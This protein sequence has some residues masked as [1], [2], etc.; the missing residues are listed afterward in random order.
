MPMSEDQ[1]GRR[2]GTLT[3]AVLRLRGWAHGFYARTGAL[4]CAGLVG[5]VLALLAF[6]E[7]SEEVLEGETTAFDSRWMLWLNEHSTPWLD[8]AALEVTVLGSGIAVVTVGVVA[9]VILALLQRR[10]YALLV[11][12]GVAGAAIFNPIL[13]VSFGRPRPQ[14]FEWRVEYAEMAS[15]PSGHTTSAT[16]LFLVLA[17]VIHRLASGRKAISYGA[18]T[19]A[20]LVPLCVGL[21]RIYLGVH[22]P[23]DVLASFATGFVWAA[24]VI[25]ATDA[26]Q[27]WR[28]GRLVDGDSA[29]AAGPAEL[30][31]ETEW[32]RKHG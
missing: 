30:E 12:A 5:A 19:V 27:R 16:A 23:T 28:L 11:A 29:D 14:L 32:S 18:A 24:F 13:K 8:R 7:L 1:R 3:E 6:S 22:Y 21:S 25:F 2:G 10:T 9:V 31:P 17:Y 26:R 4:L 15:Y 20:T